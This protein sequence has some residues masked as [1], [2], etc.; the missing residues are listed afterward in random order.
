[1]PALSFRSKLLLAMLLT[2]VG[3]TGALL[4]V[5]EKTFQ[6]DRSAQLEKIFQQQNEAFAERQNLLM[7]SIRESCKLLTKSARLQQALSEAGDEP[8]RLYEITRPELE[9]RNLLQLGPDDTNA[10]HAR[11]FVFLDAQGQV[12]PPPSDFGLGRAIAKQ[13]RLAE[14]LGWLGQAMAKHEATVGF[15]TPEREDGTVQL[16]QAVVTR[17]VESAS[18]ELLGALALAFPAPHASATQQAELKSGILVND[19]LFSTSIPPDARREL[20]SLLA[21]T[22]RQPHQIREDILFP[23][24]NEPHLLF[25]QLLNPDPQVPRAY[26]VALI[27]IQEALQRQ[28][29]L[30][31]K[32]VLFGALGLVAAVIISRL[33]SHG[34]TVPIEALVKG[35]AEIQR[36]NFAVKV[37]VR[38]RDEIGRLTSSF[39]EMAEGLALKEKY[40]SVLNMV[41]DKQVAQELMQGNVA[42]GGELRDVSVLFCD[43]RG[44]TALTQGMDP[45]EVIRMLNEHFTPLTRVAYEHNGVVDKFVGD[46]IMAVFGAPKSYGNDTRNAAQCALDMIAQ[47]SKLNETSRYKIQIGIGV[48]SGPAVA[49]CMGSTDRLNYTVLGERVNLASRLCGKAGRMEVVI[50]QATRDRLGA[51]ARVEN[52][53]ALELKGFTGTIAAY[54]LLELH[55]SPE[56]V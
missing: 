45:A 18:D 56:L 26:L 5:A 32:I 51:V 41:A 21:E 2:V 20:V 25:Y 30:R 7:A 14:Q 48:A 31:H 8:E 42:L 37:P 49:G 19:Q 38:S 29:E 44:F 50:D 23:I 6:Q 55:P 33:L 53:P 40:R 35:T 24:A 46:L 28:K 43:I 47:R 15:I 39:N 36:G 52:L 1:M 3:V 27:S 22:T 17:I 9:T 54:K 13:Q 34:L 16:Q 11:F 4:Y 10:L 12:I